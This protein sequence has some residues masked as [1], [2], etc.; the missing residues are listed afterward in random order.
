MLKTDSDGV[1]FGVVWIFHTELRIFLV[2]NVKR[3]I[4]FHFVDST[5]KQTRVDDKSNS[6]TTQLRRSLLFFLEDDC[7]FA[8]QFRT[9][10]RILIGWVCLR[11]CPATVDLSPARH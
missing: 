8:F 5:L 4:R 11:A 2:F 9:W 7:T 6:T 10:I 3:I 1:W